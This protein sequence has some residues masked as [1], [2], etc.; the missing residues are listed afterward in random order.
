MFAPGVAIAVMNPPGERARRLERI[1]LLVGMAGVA[2]WL[3]SIALTR[4]G[5]SWDHWAFERLSRGQ[6]ATITAYFIDQQVRLARGIRSWSGHPSSPPQPQPLQVETARPAPS[7][8]PAA[9]DLIG[10]LAIPRLKLMTTVREGT[11]ELTLARAVGH[12]AGTAL[13]GENGN[14]AVAGHRDTLFQNLSGIRIRDLIEFETLDARFVYQVTSTTVVKPE[15]GS[16][17][18][19][20]LYP[21]LTLVTCYPFDF[22]GSAPD[23]FIVKARLVS[24]NPLSP[25]QPAREQEVSRQE[26]PPSIRIPFEIGK[27]R[28]RQLAPGISVGVTD[29]DVPSRRVDGCVRLR[30][31]DHGAR[32]EVR[33]HR[34]G[35]P[36]SLRLD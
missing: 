16:V 17:L 20:G 32:G 24:Q 36:W 1:L 23:R 18:R 21:E 5:Q 11:G 26:S 28:S 3:G 4:L 8:P 15:T 30:T 6:P 34:V 13:P 14:V 33:V 19:A 12:I 9:N 25:A 7:R 29:I 22:I 10:R 2:V 35:R 31:C 27:A